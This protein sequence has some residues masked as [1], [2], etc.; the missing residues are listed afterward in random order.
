MQKSKGTRIDELLDY[1][2]I[3]QLEFANSLNVSTGA[4]TNWKRRDLGINVINKIVKKYPQISREWLITGEG[5]PLTSVRA[6]DKL[7]QPTGNP[8]HD[9][10][11][12]KVA[13]TIYNSQ[14]PVKSYDAR[15]GVP[16]YDVEFQLGYDL[17][18]NDQTTNPTFM[19]DFPPYNRCDAWCRAHGNSMHPTISNGDYIALKRIEDFRFLISGDI[20]A[21]VTTN[22]LR[23][24]KR[25]NDN[26]D[27][28]TLIADNPDY[29][30]QTI[31][32]KDIISVFRV[33]GGMKMF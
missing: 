21:I 29:Q 33:M 10:R 23:T 27:T 19:I 5:S 8:E 15:V 3:S 12:S 4:I 11:M 31:D 17:M 26:G 9:K 6:V 16:F 24:I 30:Q 13:E 7:F 2:Q 28:L 20:Y 14:Q 1:L 32:K 25:V 22:D 18:V